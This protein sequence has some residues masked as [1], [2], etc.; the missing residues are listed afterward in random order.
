[1]LMHIMLWI[2]HVCSLQEGLEEVV[3][4]VNFFQVYTLNHQLMEQLK[5]NTASMEIYG[6]VIEVNWRHVLNCSISKRSLVF[7]SLRGL[8]RRPSGAHNCSFWLLWAVAQ[9]CGRGDSA[10]LVFFEKFQRLPSYSSCGLSRQQTGI[11]LFPS[12]LSCSQFKIESCILRNG[13]AFE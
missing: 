3:R 7:E 8:N 5:G 9:T 6:Q 13:S 10:Q 11:V 4:M 12:I 1:M 2:L